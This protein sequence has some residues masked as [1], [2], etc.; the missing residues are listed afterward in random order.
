MKIS[1]FDISANFSAGF[2]RVANNVDRSEFEDCLKDIDNKVDIELS[3]FYFKKFQ[4]S[5]S[6]PLSSNPFYSYVLSKRYIIILVYCDEIAGS[7]Y[8]PY[9]PCCQKNEGKKVALID[10]YNISFEEKYFSN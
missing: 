2:Y 6:F 8:A 1:D 4:D 5:Y 9:C 10:F 3:E 7:D